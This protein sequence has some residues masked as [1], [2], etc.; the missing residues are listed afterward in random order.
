MSQIQ[1]SDIVHAHQHG[2]LGHLMVPSLTLM[3]IPM[4]FLLSQVHNTC[5][6]NWWW[7]HSKERLVMNQQRHRFILYKS[8]ICINQH[9][10][11]AKV[12][13]PP[14]RCGI[15]RC[16]NIQHNIQFTGNSSHGHSRGLHAN[17]NIRGIV[18]CD[19]F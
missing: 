2:S 19:T 9:F 3:V 10:S 6:E 5:R 7:Q 15:S 4:L 13:H 12:I 16:F 8:V 17:C 1:G 11:F 14:D 18:L